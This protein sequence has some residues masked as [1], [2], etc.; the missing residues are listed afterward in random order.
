M[1]CQCMKQTNIPQATRLFTDFLYQFDR[2]QSFYSFAPFDDAS[3]FQAAKSVTYAEETRA[4]V[5]AV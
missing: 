4:A 3:L 5:A 1:Q 2:V